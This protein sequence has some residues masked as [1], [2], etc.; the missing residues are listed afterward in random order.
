MI[1]PAKMINYPSTK[2]DDAVER[3]K[4]LVGSEKTHG[5]LVKI[6]KNTGENTFDRY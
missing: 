3:M 1:D 2:F 6:N 4:K 5:M